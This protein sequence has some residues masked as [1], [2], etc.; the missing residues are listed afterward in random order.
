MSSEAAELIAAAQSVYVRQ[1][2][3]RGYALNF[4]SQGTP[5][6]SASWD[7]QVSLWQ[8]GPDSTQADLQACSVLDV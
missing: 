2:D 8:C 7:H 4:A 5:P 6:I 3:A 1:C